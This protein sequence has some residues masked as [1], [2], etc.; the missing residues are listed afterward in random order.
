MMR[1]MLHDPDMIASLLWFFGLVWV[2]RRL[3]KWWAP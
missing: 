3:L 1:S 2:V